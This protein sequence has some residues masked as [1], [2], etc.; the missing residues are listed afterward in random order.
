MN[1]LNYLIPRRATLPKP[2][3]VIEL[4]TIN[5][6]EYIEKFKN[7]I[8]EFQSYLDKTNFY[9]SWNEFVNGYIEEF[10]EDIKDL[11]NPKIKYK[12]FLWLD[13]TL[14]E[15]IFL[16]TRSYIWSVA[17]KNQN[18]IET[19]E[20]CKLCLDKIDVFRNMIL[21]F[22]SGA[23][24]YLSIEEINHYYKKRN[25]MLCEILKHKDN[26][27][28]AFIGTTIKNYWSRKK[29]KFFNFIQLKEPFKYWD[30]LES[31]FDECITVQYNVIKIEFE[32]HIKGNVKY[33]IFS[34]KSLTKENLISKLVNEYGS[35]ELNVSEYIEKI[36][37]VK[38]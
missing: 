36:F 5:R 16:Y 31:E 9:K 23:Y 19:E 29:Y 4:A 1:K 15:L 37:D 14:E 18:D 38:Y 17:K 30:F 6:D 25:R 33:M 27:F 11:K 21:I 35:T 7:K 8:K 2:F 22:R 13:R 26:P 34:G 28:Y 20:N 3:K 12:N 10:E 24:D 32:V